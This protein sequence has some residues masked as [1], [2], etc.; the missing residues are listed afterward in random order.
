M[1]S[2]EDLIRLQA[3]KVEVLYEQSIPAITAALTASLV[4]IAILWRQVPISRLLGWFMVYL[5]ISALRYLL[6][7]RYNVAA[8]KTVKHEYWLNI[9]CLLSIT[10]GV[11]WGLSGA[12]FM[13]SENAIYL[14]FLQLCICGLI[15]G[16]IPSYA[17]SHRAYYSFTVPASILLIFYM[18]TANDTQLYT[19]AFLACI[20]FGFMIYIEF[21]THKIIN[22][23]IELQLDNTSLLLYLDDEK[24]QSEVVQRRWQEDTKKYSDLVDNL[25]YARQRIKELEQQLNNVNKGQE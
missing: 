17:V 23:L 12:I 16:S 19:V 6:V 21:R 25:Y 1:H 8:E 10:S 9:F 5:V 15:A 22:R 3:R 2:D 14:S 24:Q 13:L 18:A 4:V 7:Y 11:M 20:Y